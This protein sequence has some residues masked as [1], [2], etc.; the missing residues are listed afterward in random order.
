MEETKYST[1]PTPPSSS[2]EHSPNHP[3]GTSQSKGIAQR[4]EKEFISDT[5]PPLPTSFPKARSAASVP[6]SQSGVSPLLATTGNITLN[7]TKNAHYASSASSARSKVASSPARRTAS[8]PRR[9]KQIIAPPD[10]QLIPLGQKR[11]DLRTIEEIM[12]DMKGQKEPPKSLPNVKLQPNIKTQP[13][14]NSRP[15]VKAQM[16]EK[17]SAD[18]PSK[19]ARNIVSSSIE[20]NSVPNTLSKHKIILNQK[21]GTISRSTQ[22]DNQR[23]PHE[24]NQSHHKSKHSHQQAESEDEEYY[25]NN[26][27]QIISKL[28]NYDKS[29]Y[30][31]E[32]DELIDEALM[33]SSYDDIEKEEKRSKRIAVHEDVQEQLK[34]KRHAPH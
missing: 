6:F 3:V 32:M 5:L 20:S 17:S 31:N 9:T 13:N 16:N 23:L 8:V 11:R 1:I 24:I 7:K 34:S 33:E 19:E 21:N 27:S 26:Y 10:V 4:M 15:N 28:F 30:S 25:A 22:Q 2:V 14:V 12:I 18:L 29:K